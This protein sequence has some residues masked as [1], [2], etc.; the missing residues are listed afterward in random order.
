MKSRQVTFIFLVALGFWSHT[1]IFTGNHLKAG[2]VT[3]LQESN[4][5]ENGVKSL[6]EKNRPGS[7][8]SL[9]EEPSEVRRIMAEGFAVIHNGNVEQARITALRIAYAEAVGRVA[10]LE[11]SSSTWIVNVRHVIDLVTSR[12][13]GFIRSYDIVREGISEKDPKRYEVLIEAEVLEKAI[14]LDDERQ[15]LQIFLQLLGDPKILIMLPEM[16]YQAKF[17]A[18]DRDKKSA[19][20]HQKIEVQNK[21]TK[22]RIEQIEIK[23]TEPSKINS[24]PES[25]EL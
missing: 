1:C 15:G 14:T 17:V 20:K 21:D 10:G 24:V 2:S 16:E 13:K 22:I 6:L 12:S 9:T 18:G 19:D 8:Q 4:R 23:G 25:Q 7:V 11:I 5:P 3:P